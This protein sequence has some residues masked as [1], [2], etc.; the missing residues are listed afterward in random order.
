VI[1]MMQV[2]VPMTF[3]MSS[4]RQP[5]PIASQCAS[6][7]PTGMG[8]PALSPSFSAHWGERWPAI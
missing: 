7:A 2:E 5:A 8:I 6:N 4:V 3:T 1:P